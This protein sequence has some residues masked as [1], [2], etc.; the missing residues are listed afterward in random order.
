MNAPSIDIK[1]QVSEQEWQLRVDLAAAYRLV[2]MH[3][4][5]D[6]IFTHLSARV[7]GPE[8]HFLINPYGLAFEEITASS[9]VK[10]NQEGQPV[11]DTD[12]PVNY[13]GFVIH[14][15]IHAG[16]EDVV[17]VLHTHTPAGVAVSAQQDGLLPISQQASVVIPSLGYHSYEGIAVYEEEKPRLQRDLGNNQGLILRNHGLLAVGTSV[18]EAFLFLYT[19]Q[20]ACEVQVMAQ[21]GGSKLIPIGEPILKNVKANIKRV[22]TDTPG[23]LAWPALLR[24]L[25]RKYPGYEL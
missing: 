1:A 24:R 13:A 17:A 12:Y 21:A 8:H 15:A 25:D 2:A 23:G 3:G 14:S 6:L 20:R 7:P 5:D 10:V 4:W 11:I 19:L 18:A 9:L 16:R 22:S